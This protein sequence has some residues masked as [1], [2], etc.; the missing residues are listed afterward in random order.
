LSPNR[1]R[2]RLVVAPEVV[3]RRADDV[4]VVRAAQ[5]PVA[6]DHQRQLGLAGALRL[7]QRVLDIPRRRRELRDKVEQPVRVRLARCRGLLGL[8]ELAGR[9]H[10]HRARDALDVLDR[11][12]PR[13]DF[14]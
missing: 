2:Q 5:A 11:L 9:D 13:L 12:D 8:A 3:E 4:G 1:A 6:R 7:Q 14:A 10:L